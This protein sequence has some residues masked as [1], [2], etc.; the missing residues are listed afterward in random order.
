MLESHTNGTLNGRYV[1]QL[2][3]DFPIED[4]SHTITGEIGVAWMYLS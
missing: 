1:S 2:R 4:I 3:G